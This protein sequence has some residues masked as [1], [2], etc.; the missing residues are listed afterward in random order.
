M[1]FK[2]TKGTSTPCPKATGNFY[3]LLN[4]LD[5]MKKPLRNDRAVDD[6]HHGEVLL[7]HT[8][9]DAEHLGPEDNEK[10]HIARRM[11][12]AIPALHMP[13]HNLHEASPHNGPSASYPP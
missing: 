7:Y 5:H 6:L 12:P 3:G 11:E 10:E 1:T 9:H 2:T 8:S 13:L 4:T